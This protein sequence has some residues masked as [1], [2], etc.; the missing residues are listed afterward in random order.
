MPRRSGD[1]R[2]LA[3]GSFIEAIEL[4]GLF[5]LQRGDFPRQARRFKLCNGLGGEPFR[6][7]L[8]DTRSIR[9]VGRTRKSGAERSV[10]GY[11][12]RRK[13]NAES[14]IKYLARRRALAAAMAGAFR[15]CCGNDLLGGAD[16]GGLLA[17]VV[18]DGLDEG[19]FS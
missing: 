6:R 11:S 19:A 4:A 9:A 7:S 5:S 2:G 3:P 10:T 8:C 1:N 14:R 17:R 12:P 18:S 16:R 13:R 15:V